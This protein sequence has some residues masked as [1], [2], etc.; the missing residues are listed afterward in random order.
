MISSLLQGGLG[1]QMF[2]IAATTALA[3]ENGDTA[4]FSTAHHYTP[5]NNTKVQHYRDNIFRGVNIIDDVISC[6]KVFNEESYD[7]RPIPYQKEMMLVGYFQSEKYFLRHK[8]EIRSLFTIPIH[9]SQYADSKYGILSKQN[10]ASIHVRR[11]DYLT[12]PLVHPPC[13][14]SYYV[15]AINKLGDLE[16]ILIFSDD[17]AWC[18]ENLLFENAEYVEGE[19]DIVDLYL[20]SQCRCNI[21][22][23]S[24]F[25]WWGAWM[26]S[27]P[28]KEVIAPLRWFGDDG[29]SQTTKDLYCDGWSAL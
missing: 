11:G 2:Q 15:D 9:T 29:P 18:R 10:C 20:M 12:V 1:N 25:S 7:Y 3:H 16:R 19:D 5:F 21:I 24:S 17:L 13:E 8:D 27:H 6:S 4:V 14:K 22:A 26:N 23:N 28:E